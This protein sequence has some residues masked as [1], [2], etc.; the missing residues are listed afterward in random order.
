[1]IN[2]ITCVLS[3]QINISQ[4]DMLNKEPNFGFE[5]LVKLCQAKVSPFQS[6]SLKYKKEMIGSLMMLA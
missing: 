4:Q 1:M 3:N 5:T 2:R 6:N